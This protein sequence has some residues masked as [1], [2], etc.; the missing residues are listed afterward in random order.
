MGSTPNRTD[1]RRPIAVAATIRR[2]GSREALRIPED[3]AANSGLHSAEFS[4]RAPSQGKRRASSVRVPW[5]RPEVIDDTVADFFNLP[6]TA[7]AASP[8]FE[9]QFNAENQTRQLDAIIRSLHSD[10]KRGR[11]LLARNR[12]HLRWREDANRK[13]G[14]TS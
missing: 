12:E 14:E 2:S 6:S 8:W 7:V 11:Q 13:S 1:L 10:H 4:C 9:E 3:R 5:Q